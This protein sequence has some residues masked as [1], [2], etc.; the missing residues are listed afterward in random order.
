MTDVRLYVTTNYSQEEQFMFNFL[1]ESF[2]ETML[3]Q[4]GQESQDLLLLLAIL[5]KI[6]G[7]LR[8]QITNLESIKDRDGLYKKINLNVDSDANKFLLL[9]LAE[10]IRNVILKEAETE[11]DKLEI[12]MNKKELLEN[13]YYAIK[14]RGSKQAI[15]NIIMSFLAY[16]GN[17]NASY[18]LLQET[19]ISAPGIT[20]V[21]D[22]IDNQIDFSSDFVPEYNAYSIKK[23]SELYKMLMSIRPAGTLLNVLIKYIDNLI[24]QSSQD[25]LISD[26][27][28]LNSFARSMDY[29]NANSGV[30]IDYQGDKYYIQITNLLKTAPI[31]FYIIESTNTELQSEDFSSYFGVRQINVAPGQTKSIVGILQD[32]TD[33][34]SGQGTNTAIIYMAKNA[35]VTPEFPN[36]LTTGGRM[37]D[38]PKKVPTGTLSYALIA[39]SVFV[40]TIGNRLGLT[41]I[42]NNQ[43]AV[44]A[45]IQVNWSLTASINTTANIPANSSILLLFENTLS[46]IQ[47][48]HSVISLNASYMTTTAPVTSQTISIPGRTSTGGLA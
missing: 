18:F 19:D 7:K 24:I 40:T 48:V 35:F 15:N 2:P 20:V 13:D 47:T 34:T 32:N 42:N 22:Y 33:N 17:T 1:V 14:H 41:I 43:I 10:D 5:A 27:G 38:M 36:V 46:Q 44:S 26:Q 6:L 37:L 21:L 4:A 29:P 3:I 30:L 45:S 9:L 39:P 31:S 23:D 25:S 11:N 12:L 8:N 16:V 28:D